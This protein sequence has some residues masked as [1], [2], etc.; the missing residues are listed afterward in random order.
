MGKCSYD[1]FDVFIPLQARNTENNIDISL[2][3]IRNRD[4]L[5]NYFMYEDP[6]QW[7]LIFIL[8]RLKI[9]QALNTVVGTLSH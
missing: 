5:A 1:A 9:G 7:Y 6:I 4:V 8:S 3:Y 2:D